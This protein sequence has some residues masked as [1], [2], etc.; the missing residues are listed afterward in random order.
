MGDGR[1]YANLVADPRH[2]QRRRHDRRLGASAAR[3]ARAHLVANRKRS[4]RRQPR[5]LRHHIKTA[6]YGRVGVARCAY[7]LSGMGRAKMRFR[8]RSRAVAVVRGDFAAP[9]NAGTASRGENWDIA[10]T[11][12]KAIVSAAGGAKIDLA[13]LGPETAIAAGVGDRLRDAGFPVFGPNR[14]GG[15]LESSKIFAKR[16]MERHGVPTARAAVVHSLRRRMKALDGW[17]GGVVIKADGLLRA[18]ASW[19]RRCRQCPCRACR[20]VREIKFPAAAPTC[21]SKRN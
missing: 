9:G 11:D 16:F 12:G 13:V 14:S 2:H 4:A 17:P 7:S 1:T 15:R 10:A 8:W 3:A 5:R 6:R 19:L 20:V 18:R 21:C